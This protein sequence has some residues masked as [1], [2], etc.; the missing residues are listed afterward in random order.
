MISKNFEKK[1]WK[2]EAC[3]FY[4]RSWEPPCAP[5]GDFAL[6][7]LFLKQYVFFAPK[8]E[9]QNQHTNFSVGVGDSEAPIS[10]HS[11]SRADFLKNRHSR[12]RSSGHSSAR[13]R[14]DQI[15]LHSIA[16]RVT[17]HR[18]Y[19]IVAHAFH[20]ARIFDPKNCAVVQKKP[21]KNN[22][23][24]GLCSSPQ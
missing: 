9:D 23:F 8:T 24:C 20:F 16:P 13:Q 4:K 1:L 18:D 17:F 6:C 15:T 14:A 22:F 12:E 11:G 2:T 5:G 10:F 21:K 3:F 19:G 7:T